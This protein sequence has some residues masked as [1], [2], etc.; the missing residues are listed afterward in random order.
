[1]IN[2]LFVMN[3]KMKETL[4]MIVLSYFKEHF[5][6]TEF[7][8]KKNR[9]YKCNIYL[10]YPNSEYTNLSQKIGML[11]RRVHIF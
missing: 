7:I 4:F 2:T 6:I 9:K 10:L 3:L 5:Y 1:M 11:L 8:K